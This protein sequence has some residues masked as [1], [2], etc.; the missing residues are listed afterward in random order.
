MSEQPGFFDL[1]DRYDALSR[2]GD[3]LEKLGELVPWD[4][5]RRP[6]KKALKRKSRDKGGRPP[7]DD[8]FMF[9]VLVLEALYN[10][11]DDQMEYQIRDRLSFM[12]FLGLDLD[13]RAPDAKTIWLFRDTLA[14]A[15]AVEV[16]FA[17]FDNYL[18]KN[19][20]RASGG[21]LIDASLIPVPKQRNNRDENETIKAGETPE[22]WEEKPEK[23][24]QKDVEARWTKK[25]GQNHYGYKNHIN[26]DRK[27]KL[28]RRYEV[29][30]ASVH[31]SQAFESVL[32]KKNRSKDIWADSAYRSAEREETLKRKGYRSHIHHKG[33]RGRPLSEAQQRT[34]KRRSKVRARVE[35]VFGSQSQM[36]T[37]IIRSIGMVRVKAAI[38]LR[39]LAYNMQR[40]VLLEGVKHA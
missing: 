22:N 32:H 23:L 33:K 38:G 7:F 34:N 31:D 14:K 2:G 3:P 18:E 8:V 9:K 1:Q 5:F 15:E 36:G 40:Y 17:R 20:L 28:I 24:R 13:D 39:N 16:L 6:L 35:H 4:A 12:R 27:Y 37:R 11:S 25:N 30:D 21:Q 10:L 26:I 19:G 29:T